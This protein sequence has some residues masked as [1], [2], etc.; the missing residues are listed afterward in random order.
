M[1]LLRCSILSYKI[2]GNHNRS[3]F[4][5][6]KYGNTHLIYM[7]FEHAERLNIKYLSLISG[8][9]VGSSL[10]LPLEIGRSTSM[11][12]EHQW[13]PCCNRYHGLSKVRSLTSGESLTYWHGFVLDSVLLSALFPL[14]WGTF[15]FLKPKLFPFLNFG[16]LLIIALKT[17]LFLVRTFI[18]MEWIFE[19]V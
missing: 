5:I 2:T 15:P 13:P 17:L 4:C 12:I 8:S 18:S 10:L 16:M 9:E 11:S 14:L 6:W 7:I 1:T 3:C 19:H